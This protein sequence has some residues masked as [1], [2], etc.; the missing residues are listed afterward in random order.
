MLITVRVQ[1]NPVTT[2]EDLELIF[3]RFGKIKKCE[4]IRD[5]KTKQSL[6]YGFVE[7]STPAE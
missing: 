4:I 2:D 7:F 6:N 1:L 5:P 3:S